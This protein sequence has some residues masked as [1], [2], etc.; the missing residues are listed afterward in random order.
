M[1]INL[2]SKY[3]T[4]TSY[5]K[6][7]YSPNKPQSLP[8]IKKTLIKQFLN[9]QNKPYLPAALAL[10]ALRRNTS[11]TYLIPLPLY[12]SGLRNIRILATT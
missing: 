10:P 9:S 12:G 3:L 4:L 8:Q 2:T 6:T 5:S 1:F 7:I 11:P